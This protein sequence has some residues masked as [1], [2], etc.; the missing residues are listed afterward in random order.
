VFEHGVKLSDKN[1]A[2]LSQKTRGNLGDV[3][4]L[5][6][7]VEWH[8]PDGLHTPPEQTVKQRVRQSVLGRIATFDTEPRAWITG[9]QS[10]SIFQYQ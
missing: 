7:I 9:T 1:A 3:G 10:S 8:A 5:E 2:R 6:V 4:T